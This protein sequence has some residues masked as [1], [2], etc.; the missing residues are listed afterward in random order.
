MQLVQTLY[1]PGSSRG[2]SQVE[3]ALQKI[4]RSPQGWQLADALLQSQIANVRFFGALTFC[5]KINKD[6][7]ENCLYVAICAKC[8]DFG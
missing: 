8:A 2:I 7:L 6:W 1:Q 4:Q 5:I 3:R